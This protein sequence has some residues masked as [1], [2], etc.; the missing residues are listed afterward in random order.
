MCSFGSGGAGT[1]VLAWSGSGARG[2]GEEELS[3]ILPLPTVCTFGEEAR[4]SLK[5]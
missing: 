2:A 5:D 4:S 3:G 1:F